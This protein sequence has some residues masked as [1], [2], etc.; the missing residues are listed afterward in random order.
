MDAYAKWAVTAWLQ[1]LD[2][3]I[4]RNTS[5]GATAGQIL[6]C[7]WRLLS[8]SGKLKLVEEEEE[9]EEAKGRSRPRG[10]YLF[11]GSICQWNISEV[12]RP[13]EHLEVAHSLISVI[14]AFEQIVVAESYAFA[15]RL[16]TPCYPHFLNNFLFQASLYQNYTVQYVEV[17]CVPS[18]T[19]VTFTCPSQN[20]FFDIK[21]FVTLFFRIYILHTRS[22]NKVRELIAV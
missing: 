11:C 22:D 3:D 20:I 21:L 18:A 19:H 16:P 10:C 2:T 7:Q 4:C 5:L 12:H 14:N 17:W 1:T 13:L 6:K 15:R 9:K 8:S